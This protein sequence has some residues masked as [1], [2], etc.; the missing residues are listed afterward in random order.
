MRKYIL[1]SLIIIA[2]LVAGFAV[3]SLTT[4][5]SGP[6]LPL[7]IGVQTG[8]QGAPL[9]IADKEG[10]FSQNGLNVTLRDYTSGLDTENAMLNG[11]VDLS[12]P[13]EFVIANSALNNTRNISGIAVF[14]KYTHMVIIGRKDHGI[15]N[16][17]D[18]RGKRIGVTMN[19]ASEFYLG[20][21]LELNGMNIRD[22]DIVNVDVYQ[23]IDDIE[24]GS[25]D[26][27]INSPPFTDEILDNLGSNAVVWPA[28]NGQMVFEIIAGNNDWIA[29]H[30]D[31]MKRLLI[32]LERADQYIESNPAESQ[33]IVQ[34]RLNMSEPYLSSEWS[35][36][37]FTLSL[38]QSLISA[39][40]DE[41]RWMIENNMT[42]ATA[43]PDFRQYLYTDGLETVSPGSVNLY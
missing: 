25:I 29:G 1:V 5:P 24:N 18:L 19:T 38:D 15:S 30:P 16:I 9:Y 7:T 31:E 32:S 43:V 17:S 33:A 42:N 12:T 20:R 8:V 2:I 40:D 28:Q 37:Q 39:M 27:V 6:M 21:F 36:H 41:S 3:F 26:A 22:V 35:G 4:P 10:F 23:S 13:S 14:D 11:V 34:K